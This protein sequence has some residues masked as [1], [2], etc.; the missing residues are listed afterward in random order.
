MSEPRRTV[1]DVSFHPWRALRALTHIDQVWRDLGDDQL[2]HYDHRCHRVTLNTGLTQVERRCTLTHELVH[3]ERGPVAASHREREEV[4][5]EGL[6]ARR[7]IPLDA[8][9]DA[10]LWSLDESELADELWVDVPTVTARLAGLTDAER[11]HVA[12]ELDRREASI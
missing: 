7:L 12:A 9:V 11:A 3:A 5:V 10:M 4:I 8:L 2:G 1:P 6:A